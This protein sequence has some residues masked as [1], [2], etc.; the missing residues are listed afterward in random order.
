MS[1]ASPKVVVVTTIEYGRHPEDAVHTA[2][3]RALGLTAYGRTREEA[4]R[5][6]CS[7]FRSFIQ[8]TRELGQ[9]EVQLDR[10]GVAWQVV[11]EYEKSGR[12]YFDLDTLA[13][14]GGRVPGRVAPDQSAPL[15]A[16]AA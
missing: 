6:F 7:L 4:R 8:D 11:A 5:N 14:S 13:W 1:S 15:A 2:R 16:L 10:A 12:P 3:F 9:L